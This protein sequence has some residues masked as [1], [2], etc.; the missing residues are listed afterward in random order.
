MLVLKFLSW[1][2][3]FEGLLTANLKYTRLKF[4]INLSQIA[5]SNNKKYKEF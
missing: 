3:D 1:F 2:Q 4:Q 5:A